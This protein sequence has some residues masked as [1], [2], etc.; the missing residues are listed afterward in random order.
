MKLIL[1]KNWDIVAEATEFMPNSV[2]AGSLVDKILL[3]NGSVSGVF[4]DMDFEIDRQDYQLL[5]AKCGISYDEGNLASEINFQDLSL[6]LIKFNLHPSVSIY[7]GSYK[8][9]SM[10][11]F[12]LENKRP[13]QESTI[14]GFKIIHQTVESRQQVIDNILNISPTRSRSKLTENL[15][16]SQ[17]KRSL[18]KKKKVL[19]AKFKK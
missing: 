9:I 10:D 14:N 2:L 6:R 18:S 8:K 16:L 7:V 4:K 3:S 11:L 19:D 13:S 5:L 12:V 1:P 15:W 17:K